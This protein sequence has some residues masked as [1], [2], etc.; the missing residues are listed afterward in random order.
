MTETIDELLHQH[1]LRADGQEDL[2][3]ATYAPSTG[4]RRWT[5]LLRDVVTPKPGERTV[6]RNVSF[7]GDYMVRAAVQA[8][9][10]G[11]GVAILHSHLR[12]RGWQRMSPWDADAEQSY[13]HLVE[14]ITGLPLLGMTLAGVDQ[15]WSARTWTSTG[16]P[17][18]AEGVRIDGGQLRVSWNDHLRPSP[19]AQ[20]TQQRTISAWG[21]TIQAD[22]SRL[23]ILVVGVGSVGLDVAVRLAAAG[24]QHIAV[25]DPDIVKRLNLDRLI[26][27][28]RRDASLGRP[29]VDVAVQLMRAAATAEQPDIVGHRMSVCDPEAH[30]IAL[31]YDVIFS[32]VDRPWARAVL[33]S[34]AYTDLIP[35]LDGGIGIDAFD[36]GTGMR[37]ATVRTHALRP[38]RPCMVCNKQLDPALVQIDRQGL[39]DDPHYIAGA[40]PDIGGGHENVALLSP[41]V[42]VGLLNLF[43]SLIAAPG[44]EPDPGPLRFSLSTHSLEH[45]DHRSSPTCYVEQTVGIGDARP[46][47]TGA[48]G[49]EQSA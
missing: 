34:L 20:D 31:D 25:M 28:T 29:K 6:H 5:A 26:G 21:T 1:L 39:L 30:A 22:F 11:L 24:V 48:P 32:C 15:A 4:S 42:S 13:A 16:T 41:N 2:C 18:W 35:V 36:D 27:A 23:R 17:V 7:T 3:L 10:A 9:A 40:G 8:A 49:C 33:N 12:G 44:G 38:G 19:R 47:L 43:V 45:L 46:T 14:A 37:N